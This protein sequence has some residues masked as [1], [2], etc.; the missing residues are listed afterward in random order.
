MPVV[1]FKSSYAPITVIFLP[2]I[3]SSF[4]SRHH[5]D[6]NFTLCCWLYHPTLIDLTLSL[7][8]ALSPSS[9]LQRNFA[10]GL[11]NIPCASVRPGQS[12]LTLQINHRQ[13]ECCGAFVPRGEPP[14]KRLWPGRTVGDLR[15]QGEWEEKRVKQRK[16]RTEWE[17][18]R[19]WQSWS[20]DAADSPQS[21][22]SGGVSLICQLLNDDLKLA[23]GRWHGEFANKLL[24]RVRTNAKNLILKHSNLWHVIL[25]YQKHFFD[26]NMLRIFPFSWKVKFSKLKIP[27]VPCLS[28][29]S[30]TRRHHGKTVEWD[31]P[32]REG[33]ETQWRQQ[34][35]FRHLAFCWWSGLLWQPTKTLPGP[36]RQCWTAQVY[37]SISFVFSVLFKTK[38]SLKSIFSQFKSKRKK[39]IWCQN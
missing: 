27:S 39:R 24:A 18:E 22:W 2:V 35:V 32:C 34:Y 12:G 36:Q 15:K 10:A 13:K 14:T 11:F 28:A 4:S 6:W 23:T 33:L 26:C 37:A 21:P 30:E 3:H 5:C 1:N 19:E 25:I 38:T 16:Q 29:L 9:S 17:R 7:L 8:P 20:K 31:G